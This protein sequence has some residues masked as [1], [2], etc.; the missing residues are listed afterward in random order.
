MIPLN[1]NDDSNAITI[2]ST[3]SSLTDD[4]RSAVKEIERGRKIGPPR[5]VVYMNPIAFQN[6]CSII[7]LQVNSYFPSSF[8]PFRLCSNLSI[9]MHSRI[10]IYN[11]GEYSFLV[12]DEM[13]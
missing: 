3:T 5:R 11:D 7:Q 8:S 6:K 9:E 4:G 1:T 10:E 13:R 12:G 2:I